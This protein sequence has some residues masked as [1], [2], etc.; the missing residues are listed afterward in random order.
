MPSLG[1]LERQVM[2]ILWE[3]GEPLTAQ[4]L[5]E[6]L[7]EGSLALTTV[8]TVLDRLGRKGFVDRLGRG[9][10]H[11]FAA[12]GTRAAY[13]A[14]LI[15][16]ALDQTDDRAAALASFVG[17]TSQ[18]DAATLLSALRKLGRQG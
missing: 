10:P 2:A 15:N 8:L 6:Q 14:E 13:V 12:R 3:A 5:R 1:D 11:T 7:S 9:R 17:S 4:H 18:R 16:E